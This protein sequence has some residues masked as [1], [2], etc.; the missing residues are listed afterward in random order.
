MNFTEISDLI[1]KRRSIRN[2][3]GEPL[4][5]EELLEIIDIA[6][7]APSN[8]NRQGWKFFVLS[9][10][11]RIEEVAV[12]VEQDLQQVNG[13]SAV[14]DEMMKDYSRNFTIFRN[15][16]VILVCCFVKP[17]GFNFRIF[18]TDD[19]NRHFTGELISLSMAMQNILLLATSRDIGSLIMTAPL[20]SAR[21]IKKILAIPSKYTIAAFI[22]LGRHDSITEPGSRKSGEEV[23]AFID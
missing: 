16:P 11:E 6:V 4:Q 10:R 14:I 19:E 1:R 12:Q 5:R 7:H 22:C 9:T 15:A 3:S 23:V 18:E 21:A 2:F 17:A 20:I 13:K 8:N